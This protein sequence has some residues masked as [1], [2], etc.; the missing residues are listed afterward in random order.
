MISDRLK[1]LLKELNM[2]Q[3][4]F[5]IMIDINEGYFSRVIQGKSQPSSKLLSIIEKT[6]KVNIQWLEHG[7]GEIF[8]SNESLNKKK[9]IAI[10]DT[11]NE[12]QLIAV[13][14]FIKYLTEKK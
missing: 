5:A 11:L 14:S 8:T 3:R 13:S 10:L 6:F 2:S 1:I 12:D 9:I 7:E 4:Q